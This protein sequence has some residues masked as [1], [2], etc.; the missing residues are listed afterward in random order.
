MARTDVTGRMAKDGAMI[1]RRTFLAGSFG[2]L[3]VAGSRN[4]LAA[5]TKLTVGYVHSTLFA[6]VFIAAERGYFKEAG[7]DANLTPIVAGQD[8]M[9]LAATGRLDLVAAALSA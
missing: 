7:F 5:T 1:A 2:A 4:A 9:A 6:P 3:A 8:A